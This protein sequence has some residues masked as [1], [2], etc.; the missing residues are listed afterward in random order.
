MVRQGDVGLGGDLGM[1]I[2][3]GG[4]LV[5]IRGS[6]T[7]AGFATHKNE[8]NTISLEGSCFPCQRFPFKRN[9]F[10]IEFHPHYSEFLFHVF[11]HQEGRINFTFVSLL[12]PKYF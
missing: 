11:F 8:V 1:A 7:P 2:K 4:P 5:W 10:L 9:I 12:N 6:W 3:D